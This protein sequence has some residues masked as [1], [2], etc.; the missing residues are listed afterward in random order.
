M[1][2]C[3]ALS[4]K[5]RP[6]FTEI[7]HALGELPS[8]SKV[9]DG[10][11]HTSEGNF[12]RTLPPKQRQECWIISLSHFREEGWGE[13]IFLICISNR[14]CVDPTSLLYQR[15]HTHVCVNGFLWAVPGVYV[16]LNCSMDDPPL[17][18]WAPVC[19][20]TVT[21]PACLRP[22]CPRNT[23]CHGASQP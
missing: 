4:L 2:R 10:H 14:G 15:K 7:V 17:L 21:L 13:N 9:W 1:A 22:L 6:S 12:T 16:C 20:S 3:W 23:L 19:G 11:N 8:D 18:L 5:E